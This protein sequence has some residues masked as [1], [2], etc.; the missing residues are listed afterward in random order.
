MGAFL[1][2]FRVFFGAAAVDNRPYSIVGDEGVRTEETT[3]HRNRGWG[4]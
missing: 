2:Q 3:G 1:Q 4:R